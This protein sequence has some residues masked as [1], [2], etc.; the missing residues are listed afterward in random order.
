MLGAIANVRF[1]KKNG[2]V[3][4]TDAKITPTICHYETN[5]GVKE[6]FKIYKLSEY[7]DTLAAEHGIKVFLNSSFGRAMTL[8]NMK[9]ISKNVLK[10]WY[11]EEK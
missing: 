4:I 11:T 8:E 9:T 2:T 10:D 3:S 1:E 6:H 7:T 5:N